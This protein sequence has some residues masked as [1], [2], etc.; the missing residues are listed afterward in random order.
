MA[1]VLVA[2]LLL[3]FAVPAPGEARQTESIRPIELV[4]A[5]DD[6][7]EARLGPILESGG[8][9]RSLESGLP[10]R[11]RLVVELWRDR[12]LDS[13][14]DRFEWRA[15]VRQDPLSDRF[16]VETGDGLEQDVFSAAAARTALQNSLEIPL[17]PSQSGNHYYLARLEV[18]TLS[19]SDLEELRRWLQGDLG[20][21]VEGG[22]EV[23]GAVGRGLRRLL[24][25]VL[26][27]PVQRYEARTRSFSVP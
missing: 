26:G 20:P 3:L 5:G 22:T 2:V 25:R 11:I 7:V 27:L 18:E 23:G 12:F 9:A 19:L 10:V 4:L 6:R 16:I 21:A 13:Q 17:A 15:S 24:V 1:L 8:V 14:E